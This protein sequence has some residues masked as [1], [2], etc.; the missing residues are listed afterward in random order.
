M[1]K[2]IDIG[3]YILE[4]VTFFHALEIFKLETIEILQTYSN[5]LDYIRVS[6]KIE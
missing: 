6:R 4:S 2:E 1:Y 3:T 5:Y